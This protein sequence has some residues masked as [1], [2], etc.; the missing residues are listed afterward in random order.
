MKPKSLIINT[1]PRGLA[2][3]LQ[4]AC[5][6]VGVDVCD[7]PL[8][9]LQAE[10]A[11]L[12]DLNRQ[13]QQADV[14][15]FVSPSA[16]H[17]AAHYVDWQA[18]SGSLCAVGAS[19]A[20]LLRE[21][22]QKV[23]DYPQDGN[24]S[25]ALLRLPLWREKKGK[26]LIIRGQ[27]G[28]NVLAKS[29]C[30]QGWQV[31]CLSVYRRIP[32][33][34]SG[35]EILAKTAYY[36]NTAVLISSSEAAQLWLEQIAFSGSDRWK[37]LLYFTIHARIAERLREQGIKNIIISACKADTLLTELNQ[38]WGLDVEKEIKAKSG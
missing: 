4:A 21:I 25:E 35:S 7:L 31:D 23:V 3:D 6:C 18:F 22:S 32:R 20:H 12:S 15:F 8:L 11:V 17:I 28:R 29:V 27:N 38:Q 26:L 34:F 36:A 24:D 10:Y 13:A 14:L 37:N 2:H 33:L 30:A 5:R 1:R 19:S 16:I 9:D